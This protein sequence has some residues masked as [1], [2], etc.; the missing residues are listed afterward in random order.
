MRK[1]SAFVPGHI[2]GF[3][4]ICDEPESPLRKGSRNCGICIDSGVHTS[5][6]VEEDGSG[7]N[8]FI[9]GQEAIASTTRTAVEGVLEGVDESFYVRVDH[10]VQAP[11]GAGYGMS[12]AGALGATLSLVEALGL[13][14]DREDCFSIAHKA[15]V[16]CGSGLGDVGPQMY[17]GLVI[18]KEPGAPPYGELERIDLERSFAVVCG[19]SGTISTA[20]FL[21][22]KSSRER[23]KR[24]GER[25]FHDMVSDPSMRTFMKVSREFAEGLG[26]FD[27]EFL[28]IIDDISQASPVGASAVMLGE[29]IFA[30]V[31]PS[32]SEK[33]RRVF[34][35]FFDEE[36]VMVSS[37]D[38]KGA[39]VLG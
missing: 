32:E 39:R 26:A 16:F 21:G 37:L 20:D 10:S 3:F 23:A 6:E 9:D 27:T 24:S 15:E 17:G 30:P 4:Q 22:D 19:T 25:A 5:T 28:K 36:S 8:I 7:T 34:L 14:L 18:G 12:G 2:S 13:S 11:I 33:V 1:S 29:A 38:F 35:D 31:F